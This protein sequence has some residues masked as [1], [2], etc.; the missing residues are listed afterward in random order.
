M[1]APSNRALQ[2][3]FETWKQIS[4]SEA[5]QSQHKGCTY[6]EDLE[7]L[8]EALVESEVHFPLGLV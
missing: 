1:F 5:M 7:D 6:A 3:D 2:V 8:V 4:K